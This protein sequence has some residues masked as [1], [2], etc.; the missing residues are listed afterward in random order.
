MGHR[1]QLRVSKR[2]T[3]TNLFPG[4]SNGQLN[5]ASPHAHRP[6]QVFSVLYPSVSLCYFG[7]VFLCSL[8]L[9]VFRHLSDSLPVSAFILGF[10]FVGS[11]SVCFFH[12][13]SVSP[14]LIFAMVCCATV[15]LHIY[16]F[17]CLS[18]SLFLVFRLLFP[19]YLVLFNCLSDR[20]SQ[21]VWPG[22]PYF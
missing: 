19:V 18:V 22:V 6:L 2:G 21:D 20:V 17:T 7:L 16:L 1:M 13:L 11:V 10:L 4:I 12:V 15:C 9:S 14:C 3:E 5:E 8:D